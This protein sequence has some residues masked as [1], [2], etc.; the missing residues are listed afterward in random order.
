MGRHDHLS[1]A[2]EMGQETAS[3]QGR[4]MGERSLFSP[5]RW[6]RLDVLFGW[7][8]EAL[9]FYHRFDPH[10]AARQDPRRANPL[11]PEW[12]QYFAARKLAEKTRKELEFF[13]AELLVNRAFTENSRLWR[14]PGL[15]DAPSPVRGNSSA[16]FRG[17]DG[18]VMC[19][20]YPTIDRPQ[21]G[22][23]LLQRGEGP[24]MDGKG[25]ATDNI[26]TERLWRSLKYEEVYLNE[27][28]I[29]RRARERI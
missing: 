9:P 6:P 7:D 20:P 5:H 2:L 4:P 13:S 11:H 14:N 18:A 26:F 15:R 3:L 16:G 1:H 19:C 21:K 25:R 8:H 17:G 24:Y 10:P 27:Y 28:D 22:K 29:P 23:N 12:D